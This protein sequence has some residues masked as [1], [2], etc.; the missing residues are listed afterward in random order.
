M[1]WLRPS[2]L[3]LALLGFVLVPV[4][5]S[6]AA[7]SSDGSHTPPAIGTPC[8]TTADC[9]GTLFCYPGGTG[10]VAASIA[11]QCTVNCTGSGANDGCK[12]IDPNATCMG[13][14]T[15]CV[16]ECGSG[17]SCPAGTTCSRYG[18]CTRN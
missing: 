11:G 12:T 17:V 3:L 13:G 10:T 9:G 14:V 1:T 6:V 16:R 2:A 5:G 15:V 7:C 8:G 18:Y 4:A